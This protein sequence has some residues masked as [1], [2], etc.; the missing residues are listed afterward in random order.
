[1]TT[2]IV[3]TLAAIAAAGFFLLPEIQQVRISKK[4]RKE[5]RDSEIRNQRW[6]LSRHWEPPVTSTDE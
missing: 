4:L 5:F 2:I 6:E 1:M 3:Y